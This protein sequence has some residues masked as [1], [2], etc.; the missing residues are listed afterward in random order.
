MKIISTTKSNKCTMER[1]FAYIFVA[2]CFKKGK[3][4]GVKKIFF[5]LITFRILN[6]DPSKV[7]PMRT[8]KQSTLLTYLT[9]R[10]NL[11]DF[12]FLF[13]ATRTTFSDNSKPP[14]ALPCL[15]QSLVARVVLGS[16]GYR[17]PS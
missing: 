9:W 1:L 7:F 2:L 16:G 14:A 10:E 6:F 5:F 8:P 15:C 3:S 17:A 12:A 13:S 11:G 4:K